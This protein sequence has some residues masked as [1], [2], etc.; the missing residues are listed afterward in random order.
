MISSLTTGI[1]GGC[2]GLV[3]AGTV[4]ADDPAIYGSGSTGDISCPRQKI[5]RR[6]DR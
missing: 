5:T 3:R 4:A 1:A 6:P 2:R